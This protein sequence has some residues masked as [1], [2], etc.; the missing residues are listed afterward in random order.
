MNFKK[1]K[2]DVLLEKILV[3]KETM[4]S[5]GIHQ[6]AISALNSASLEYNASLTGMQVMADRIMELETELKDS[7][8]IEYSHKPAKSRA[9]HY[10]DD[11]QVRVS[12][13]L[14][15]KI[16]PVTMYLSPKEVA[17]LHEQM[18]NQDALVSIPEKGLVIRPS[19][20]IRIV[21]VEEVN[22]G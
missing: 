21:P 2:Y 4:K 15:N 13:S 22:N 3:S 1:N 17:M 19:D 14:E 9:D 20:I 5:A 6:F 11:L 10:R 12:I 8:T 16:F 18:D 7:S